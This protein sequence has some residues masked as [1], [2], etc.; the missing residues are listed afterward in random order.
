MPKTIQCL[1]IA[2]LHF[3]MENYGQTNPKTGLHTRLEDFSNSMGQAVEYAINHDVDLVLFAGDAYKRNSPSPTEQRELAKHFI[4][5][6]D[7][8]IPIVMIAGNHDIPVMQGKATAV[9]IFRQMRPELITVY[10]TKP[11]LEPPIIHTKNGDIG[12]C[13]MP[14]ISPSYLRNVVDTDGL[15]HDEAKDKFVDFIHGIIEDMPKALPDEIP[16]VLMAHGTAGKPQLGGYKGSPLFMD[17]LNILPS[18]MANA[19]YSYVALGHIHLHQDLS[20][21]PNVPVVYSGSIDRIDFGESE[22]DKGFVIVSVEQGGS[23]YEYHPVKVREMIHIKTESE[24]GDDIT[25]S[26]L[27]E[28][29]KESPRLEGAIVKITYTADDDEVHSLDMKQIHEALLPVHF[30]AGFYRQVRER[31]QQRRSRSLSTEITFA[32]AFN[33]F[34][35]EHEEWKDDREELLKRALEIEKKVK[36]ASG[37]I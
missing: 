19:G 21:N 23:E 15:S 8:K 3:G 27:R 26:I 35:Q 17:E 32:D 10:N 13:C 36:A 1:H 11:T 7:A 9:D 24:R 5:L 31:D 18:V 14:F 29:R 37:I 20:P 25:E 6:A 30:K 34:M 4:T 28:I 2:D 12:V 33:A 22:E 16:K